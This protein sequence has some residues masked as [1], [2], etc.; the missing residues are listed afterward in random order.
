MVAFPKSNPVR[1]EPYRRYVAAL[2][3][4]VCRIEGY[5]QAAHADFGKG[6]GIKSC[7]LT[8]YPL[9]AP[10]NGH[11]GCHA[12]VGSSGV[13][14]RDERRDLEKITATWTQERLIEQSWSDHR[15]RALLL[16]LGV[17]K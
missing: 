14:P 9:C 4:Y 15:L 6:M 2:P 7:D 11:P 12:T 17:V 10:H 16:K 1:S 13:L 5:S 3:C 8:C